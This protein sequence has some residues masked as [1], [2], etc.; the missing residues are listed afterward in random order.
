MA[1]MDHS[2]AP[3]LQGFCTMADVE[4]LFSPREH[5]AGAEPGVRKD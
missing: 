1:W 5:T 4:F 2:A 3:L